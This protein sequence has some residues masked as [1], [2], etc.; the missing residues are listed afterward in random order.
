MKMKQQA[1]K[2]ENRTVSKKWRK[3]RKRERKEKQFETRE[4]ESSFAGSLAKRRPHSRE[5]L[6]ARNPLLARTSQAHHS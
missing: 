4:R 6:C 3:E 5:F 1:R 2:N